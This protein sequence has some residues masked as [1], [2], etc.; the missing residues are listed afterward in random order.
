[1]E[2]K[3]RDKDRKT[4]R[5]NRHSKTDIHKTRAE[6]KETQGQDRKSDVDR[7]NRH[8]KTYLCIHTYIKRRRNRKT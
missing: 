8:R 2:E 4:N 1:M 6:E 3:D 7:D 5:V